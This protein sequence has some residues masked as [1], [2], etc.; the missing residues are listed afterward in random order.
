KV[1]QTF[2]THVPQPVMVVTPPWQRFDNIEPGF[3]VRFMATVKNHGLIALNDLEIEGQSFSWGSMVPLVEYLPRLDPFQEVQIPIVVNYYG[4]EGGGD[5]AQR[6]SAYSQC[7][8]DMLGAL[9][10]FSDN[11]NNLIDR[12]SGGYQCVNSIDPQTARTVIQAL[13]AAHDEWGNAAPPGLY[14]LAIIIGCGLADSSGSGSGGPGGGPSTG[15]GTAYGSGSPVCMAPDTSVLLADGQRLEA[16][17]LA[18]GDRVR[19]GSEEHEV[20]VVAEVVHGT[21]AHWITLGFEDDPEQPL[22]VTDEH[23]VWIDGTG[24]VAAKNVQVGDAVFTDGGLRI[25]VVSVEA[26]EEE[27]PLVSVRLNGG[28]A[29]FAEGILVH[30][31]CGW[32]TPTDVKA[33]NGEVAP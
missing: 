13:L 15:G 11:L 33:L 22:T 29:M 3:Q 8:R 17:L 20:A 27:R 6:Q 30:D 25:Q 24:W 9:A 16:S 26:F 31:Q 2:E 21:G 19:S 10:N 28:N 14:E 4:E 12:F 7:L 32:W 5:Q 18:V 1:E 23:L